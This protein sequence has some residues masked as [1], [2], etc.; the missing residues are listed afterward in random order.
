MGYTFRWIFLSYM[1]VDHFTC[2]SQH[3]S[4]IKIRVQNTY[5]PATGT[6]LVF[7]IK[8]LVLLLYIRK[9]AQRSMKTAPHHRTR[10]GTAR[11]CAAVSYIF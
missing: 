5:I 10:H 2:I 11:H 4:S 6:Y 8:N 1:C 9:K 7:R 3:L